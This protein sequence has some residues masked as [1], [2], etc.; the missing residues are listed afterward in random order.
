MQ[1]KYLI[2]VDSNNPV[3]VYLND[4]LIIDYWNRNSAYVDQIVDLLK[5]EHTFKVEYRKV[6]STA[7]LKVNLD[8][9]EQ[10]VFY[11]T[12]TYNYTF[13]HMLDRQVR[14][15]SNVTDKTGK[16]VSATRDEISTFV[17]PANYN[18]K[19]NSSYFQYMKL[20]LTANI[21]VD[22]VNRR[23]LTN[24]TGKL[25]GT[26]KAFKDAGYEFGVNEIYLI[27]HALHETGYGRSELA[28]G[29][30]VNG[31][32]VYNFF[33]IA[34]YDGSAVV[35]GS[36]YA[37]NKGWTT[38]EKAI[39]GGAEWIANNYIKRGQDTLYKMKWNPDAPATHQ[40]ATDIGWAIKITPKMDDIYKSIN[41]YV[42]FFEEPKFL[43]QPKGELLE[44]SYPTGVKGK[45]NVENLNFRE[46][47]GTSFNRISSKQQLPIGTIVEVHGRNNSN[48]NGWYKITVDGVTGWVAAEYLDLLNLLQV[49]VNSGTLNVRSSS[50][51]ASSVIGSLTK[52]QYI[53]GS[54]QGN[55][56]NQTDSWYEI[57]FG[58]KKGWV[59]KDYIKQIR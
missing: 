38:P 42:L 15:G 49:N 29:V 28:K 18:N 52:D 27:A 33:G 5:G 8:Q 57:H 43:D 6:N 4:Q 26:A 24:N 17:N 12:V 20:N 19:N 14:Y 41:S 53:A 13:E 10:A 45:V 32:T 35:S 50:S 9:I 3:R 58:N 59:S 48:N 37:Y 7:K 47:P 36:Q 40:Y 11:D 46:G 23:V 51:T 2:H 21:N 22:E 44:I 31:V 16:W 30:K 56:L 55:D 39:R 25:A 1:E 54:L 34:A